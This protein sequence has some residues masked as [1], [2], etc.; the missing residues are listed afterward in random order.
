MTRIIILIIVAGNTM[1]SVIGFCGDVAVPKDPEANAA[2][3]SL[4]EDPLKFVKDQ[5]TFFDNCRDREGVPLS[6]L[7]PAGKEYGVANENS[8]LMAT[9]GAIYVCRTPKGD[10]RSN[11]TRE[12]QNCLCPN[13]YDGTV[14][15]IRVKKPVKDTTRDGNQSKPLGIYDNPTQINRSPDNRQD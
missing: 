13:G 12:G 7:S 10:C 14:I 9:N 15:R 4:C 8:L 3:Q 11:T 5:K 6:Y 2:R 1:W